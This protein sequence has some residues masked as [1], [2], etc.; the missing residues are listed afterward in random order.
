MSPV[1]WANYFPNSF[2]GGVGINY[3]L[4]FLHETQFFPIFRTTRSQER[5]RPRHTG[6]RENPLPKPQSSPKLTPNLTTLFS[7]IPLVI[8]A[9]SLKAHKTHKLTQFPKAAP[10][11]SQQVC[12]KNTQ[13]A[14]SG[15]MPYC[16]FVHIAVDIMPCSGKIRRQGGLSDRGVL[17]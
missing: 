9:R 2:P 12:A 4:S 5:R 3:A 6:M 17:S 8:P 13:V 15:I 7:H 14:G 11:R 16:G 1:A 10:G